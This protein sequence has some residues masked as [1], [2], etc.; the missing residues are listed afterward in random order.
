[1]PNNTF[2][3]NVWMDA[4]LHTPPDECLLLAIEDSVA[5]DETLDLVMGFYAEGEYHVGTAMGGDPLPNDKRVRFWMVPLW[6]EG[7]DTN[8]IRMEVKGSGQRL[9][10]RDGIAYLAERMEQDVLINPLLPHGFDSTPNDGRPVS[11]QKWWNLPYVVTETI[12]EMDAFYADRTDDHAEAGRKHW[13]DIRK[14]W[15]ESW[16]SGIRY[17][18]RCLDGGAWDRSTNWGAFASLEEAL[19]CAHG[20]PSWRRGSALA[21]GA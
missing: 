1:M 5:A 2:S 15:L 4:L 11:H 21:A 18:V 3:M 9:F 13:G 16:P 8:G 7:Y 14:K 19:Q 20:G 6:P 17:D 10:L 12:A